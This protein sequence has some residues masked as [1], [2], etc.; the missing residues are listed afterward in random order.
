[1]AKRRPIATPADTP[2]ASPKVEPV[3]KKAEPSVTIPKTEETPK[4]PKEDKT[5]KEL[6]DKLTVLKERG[7]M[8]FKKQAFKEAVKCFSEAINIFEAAGSPLTSEDIKTK[9]T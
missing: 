7:N 4:P 2:V 5:F 3:P 8:H 9:V 1:M 6:D